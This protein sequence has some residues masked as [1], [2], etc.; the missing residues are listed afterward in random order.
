MNAVATGSFVMTKRSQVEGNEFFAS[1]K[2]LAAER[3][4][5]QADDEAYHWRL[6]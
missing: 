1:L 6:D 4:E 5:R 2:I 3:G